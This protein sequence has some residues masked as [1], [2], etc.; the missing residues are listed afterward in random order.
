MNYTLAST[1]QSE[2]VKELENIFDGMLLK[3][4]SGKYVKPK[5][6]SQRLPLAYNDDDDELNYAP[7]V[8]VMLSDFKME[9]WFGD[10]AINVVLV[11]CTYDGSDERQGDKDCHLIMDKVLERFGKHPYLGGFNLEMPIEGAFQ[12]KDTYPIFYGALELHFTSVKVE[13]E[14]YLA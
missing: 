2:L 8:I 10:K 4:G 7:Y 12:D 11:I 9:E 14:D 6:Y 13:T 5:V 3:S 1:L